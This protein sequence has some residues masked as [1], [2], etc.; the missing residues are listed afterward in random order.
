MNIAA[1][2]QGGS[3]S[4]VNVLKGHAGGE[5]IE[6]VEF[7]DLLGAP[8]SA[9]PGPPTHVITA[10]TEGKA[11]IW[12]LASS[13]M[14]CEVMHDAA[15]T[16]LV[17]HPGS[18]LFTTSS[19]DHTARTW[20]ARTGACIATHKGFTDGVLALAVGKDDGF[21]QGAESGGIGAYAQKGTHGWKIVGAGD[22]GVALVFRV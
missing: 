18:P 19:A 4:V 17:L 20:D 3:A 7:V 16:S 8:A 21:T 12:D 5:S 22:E 9:A 14:R 6:A 2:D 10:S 11:I 15:I 1:L 13:K